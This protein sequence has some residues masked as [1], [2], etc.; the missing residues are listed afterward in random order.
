M[1]GYSELYID[2]AGTVTQLVSETG[3]TSR[4]SAGRLVIIVNE[5]CGT[6]CI[7][8]FD[9]TDADVACRELGFER[10]NAFTTASAIGY[11]NWYFDT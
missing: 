8:S 5:E 10:A 9:M 4:L 6:V 1:H 7:N 3:R 2:D 11:V